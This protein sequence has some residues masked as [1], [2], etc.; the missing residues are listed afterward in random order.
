[1]SIPTMTVTPMTLDLESRSSQKLFEQVQTHLA[2]L[3][4]FAQTDD[5]YM[6]APRFNSYINILY[7]EESPEGAGAQL[8]FPLQRY[9]LREHLASEYF[10]STNPSSVIST[11]EEMDTSHLHDSEL[12]FNVMVHPTGNVSIKV[13]GN[14]EL[15][16]QMTSLAEQFRVELNRT[17][18][19]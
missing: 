7:P 8:E 11:I 14:E 17:M 12:Y 3:S 5:L 13:S 2:Q 1:M 18:G 10:T 16:A 4:R 19:N 15:R 6:I 9:R